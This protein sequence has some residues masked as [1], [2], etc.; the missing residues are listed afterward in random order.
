MREISERGIALLKQFEGFSAV[1]YICAG[2]ELTVGY[3]HVIKPFERHLKAGI[4]QK[5]ADRLLRE[6]IAHFSVQIAH[7]VD[8]E[9]DQHQYD[10]LICFIYNIGAQAFEKST[11]LRMLN[12]GDYHGAAG[13]FRRWVYSRGR[14]LPGLITRRKAEANLF[15]KNLPLT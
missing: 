12:L 4:S 14:K 10:A 7:M 8:V 3:G 1:P 9:L 6:D 11:L 15:S 5:E 13:Q 2:G